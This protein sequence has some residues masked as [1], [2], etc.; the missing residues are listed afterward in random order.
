[1]GPM[2]FVGH[3]RVLVE[4]A[5]G[6]MHILS[7]GAHFSLVY[8]PLVAC[9]TASCAPIVVTVFRIAPTGRMGGLLAQVT[10]CVALPQHDSFVFG[11]AQ[12][13]LSAYSSCTFILPRSTARVRKRSG[14][15]PDQV[16]S[17]PD[18]VF[19]INAQ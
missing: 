19:S 12:R 9:F 8:Y 13:W 7:P 14:L 17:G 1:M 16:W 10:T 3:K 6:G 15:I 2:R 18:L 4:P 5:A 11:G